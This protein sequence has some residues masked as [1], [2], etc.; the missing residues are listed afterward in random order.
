[1]KI[2]IP[3]LFLLL[4]TS[5]FSQR[6]EV[7]FDGGFLNDSVRVETVYLG[8]DK[9]TKVVFDDS[10]NTLGLQQ[11]SNKNYLEVEYAGYPRVFIKFYINNKFAGGIQVD[12]KSK[13]KIKHIG[14]SNLFDSLVF[15]FSG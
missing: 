11:R 3:I 1:M 15:N 12:K 4:I 10:V 7:C 5:C 8:E 9:V 2:Y 14:V 6:I 13:N